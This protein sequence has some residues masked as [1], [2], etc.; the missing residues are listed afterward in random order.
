MKKVFIPLV[1][2]FVLL[3]SACGTSKVVVVTATPAIPSAT[4]TPDP[5][6]TTNLSATVKPLNDLTRQFDDYSALASNTPQSQLVQVIP[7]MQTIRRSAED[8]SVP[9]CLEQLKKFQ[10]QYMD[11][12]I[13]TLLAFESNAKSDILNAGIAQARQ[14]HQ[15]Y[16]IELARLLG[17]TVVV[18]PAST[19]SAQTPAATS[20]TPTPASAAITVVNPGPNPINLHVSASLTSQTIST[21]NVGTSATAIGKTATGEW[22]LIQI[23]GQP[24]KTAW[25]YATLIKFSAGDLASLPVAPS[26]P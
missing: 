7:P 22:V 24:G 12:T 20:T 1:G 25:L 3:L 4:S 19:P 26:T 17:F 21:L 15:Q 18:S 14:Y 6:G 9:S 16:A 8:L 2:F 5:C 10:L 11:T 13:Q 23:P